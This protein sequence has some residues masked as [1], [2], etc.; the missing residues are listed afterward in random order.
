MGAEECGCD[1]DVVVG[2]VG[3]GSDDTEAG[4]STSPKSPE[5]IGVG[6]LV[7]DDVSCIRKDDAVLED[8]VDT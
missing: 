2:L 1:G 4:G 3:G 5:E 6:E 7:C 8:V